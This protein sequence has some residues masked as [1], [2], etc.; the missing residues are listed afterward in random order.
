M[1]LAPALGLLCAIIAIWIGRD[2]WRCSRRLNPGKLAAL[3][4]PVAAGAVLIG[5]YNYLRF[6]AWLEFGQRFQLTRA[7]YRATPHLFQLANA[8][9]GLFSYLLRPIA[10]HNMFPFVGALPGDRLFPRFIGLPEHY[11]FN[12]P[13]AGLLLVTPFVGLAAFPAVR[14]IRAV[15]SSPPH[16]RKLVPAG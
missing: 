14:L 8:A 11:E 13:I 16:P 10:F 3:G 5:T 6:G 7:N 9:P 4:L 12:E 2:G 1:S 15:L